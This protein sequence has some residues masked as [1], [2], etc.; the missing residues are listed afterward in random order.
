LQQ[1]LQA[2]TITTPPRIPFP[3]L[4]HWLLPCRSSGLWEALGQLPLEQQ[5][6]LLCLPAIGQSHTLMLPPAGD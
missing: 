6:V 3:P 5:Y 2:V 4:L 1:S